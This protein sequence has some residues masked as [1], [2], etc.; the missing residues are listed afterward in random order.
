MAPYLC[1]SSFVNVQ[2]L[3]P[4]SSWAWW[5]VFALRVILY[6]SLIGFFVLNGSGLV[7]WDCLLWLISLGTRLHLMSQHSYTSSLEN[8]QAAHHL[9]ASPVSERSPSQIN[10][11]SYLYSRSIQ[12]TSILKNALKVINTFYK[13]SGIW[14]HKLQS[15]LQTGKQPKQI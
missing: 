1:F 5:C 15:F 8:V 11:K 6:I 13:S 4:Q 14:W 7:M 2:F 12:I 9:N 10:S 3:D